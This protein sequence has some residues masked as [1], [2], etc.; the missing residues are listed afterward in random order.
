MNRF[1]VIVLVLFLGC[2]DSPQRSTES[3]EALFDADQATD[4]VMDQ[5]TSTPQGRAEVERIGGKDVALTRFQQ[6]NGISERITEAA[7]KEWVLTHNGNFDWNLEDVKA[8]C[9]RNKKSGIPY[10]Y[11]PESEK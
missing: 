3:N 9:L 11:L 5:L 4:E 8:I 2:G 6:A 7:I 1:P 10:A